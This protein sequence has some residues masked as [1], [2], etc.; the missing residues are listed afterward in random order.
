MVEP[1]EG[2]VLHLPST[3]ELFDEQPAVR[4]QEHVGRAELAGASRPRIAAVYSATL[5]V[6]RSSA[7]SATTSPSSSVISTP[8]PAGP[9]LPRAAAVT[10][11]DQTRTTIDAVEYSP[12]AFG[13]PQAV[14]ELEAESF[15][16][17]A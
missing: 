1:L 10:M 3:G 8:I 6:A 9:G 11:Q 15:S 13:A 14:R 4:A 5:L 17:Q 16:W 12:R 7:I 2:W